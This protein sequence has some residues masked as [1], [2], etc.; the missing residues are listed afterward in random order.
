M[1]KNYSLTGPNAT[2]SSNK[3]LVAVEGSNVVKTCIFD[4]TVGSQATPADQAAMYSLGRFTVI[5]TPASTPTPLLTDPS[6]TLASAAVT[7]GTGI[8]H[9][10]E[11]TYTAGGTL[12]NIPL[13]QRATFRY[14]ASPGAEF[15]N[16]IAS[17][18]GLGF[19]L[20]AATASL[21]EW[22]TLIWFE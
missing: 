2:G 19:Y 5:G 12:L 16:T 13:N 7:A 20:S 9:S 18:N 1:A 21:I 11:P 10:G 17:A 14:V 15:C 4:I 3:S 22:A 6:N 8:T